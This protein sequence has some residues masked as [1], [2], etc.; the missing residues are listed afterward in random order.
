MRRSRSS[1]RWFTVAAGIAVGAIAHCPVVS[2]SEVEEAKADHKAKPK[3]ATVELPK[4]RRSVSNKE[5][6]PPAR[7]TKATQDGP[8]KQEAAPQDR[9]G[10]ACPEGMLL[11]DGDYCTQ[12][13][14]KCAESWY[15]K[16]NK[17]TVCERFEPWSKCTGDR[18]HKR[19]C[20]D[21]YEYPNRAGE[22]P[23]VMNK[24]NQAQVK[25]AALGKRLCTETEWTMACEGPKYKPFP[26]GYVRDT[27]IC[28]GD[29][30]WDS[31]D[32]N[33]VAA[34]DPAELARLWKG[35][36]SGSQPEC[37]SDYG[38]YDM[39][40]NAD[41]VVSSETY[42]ADFR[43]KFDSVHTGGPWYKGVR[44]QC[45][46]KIYTHD[47]GFYY[48][49]LSFRCCAEPDRKPTDPRTPKQRKAN[50][51][52]DKVEQTAGFTRQD[53]QK[54]LKTKTEKG[55]CS[56]RPKD[57]R[58]KTIC[59]TLLGPEAHDFPKSRQRG[60]HGEHHKADD[61]KANKSPANSSSPEETKGSPEGTA[62]GTAEPEKSLK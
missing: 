39:P 28:H 43:G 7:H 8:A 53:V 15:D 61:A 26:Y 12:V 11:V 51:K 42:A 9:K 56:C 50:W 31:P 55:N 10:A 17:K 60:A 1:A 58:C 35:V 16:S 4:S 45:R 13:E 22:R 2:A 29:V 38:V 49:F 18:E 25:C 47:E 34:R 37:V 32:M 23:E 46:P 14:H 21:R 30:M 5:D 3:A 36:R 52:F 24:Y 62:A 54:A 27:N 19:F 48:Y 44:N 20:M 33:K 59:G 6:S 57:V 40:G 41:E